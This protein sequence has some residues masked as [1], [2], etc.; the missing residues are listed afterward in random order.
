MNWCLSWWSPDGWVQ[1][2]VALLFWGGV[3]GAG[4]WAWRRRKQRHL[5]TGTASTQGVRPE[6]GDDTTEQAPRVGAGGGST[7]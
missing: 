5:T 4:V 2:L 3:A 1:G 7:R 6:A